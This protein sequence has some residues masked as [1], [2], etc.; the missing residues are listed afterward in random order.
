MNNIHTRIEN[1]RRDLGRIGKAEKRIS[2]Q[3][4]EYR[5]TLR[6]AK[7]RDEEQRLQKEGR[8]YGAGAF[9]KLTVTAEPAKRRKK[10]IET[11]FLTYWNC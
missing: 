6:Q 3:H 1:K 7:K 8:T 4:K 5:V 11:L 10:Y 2:D 9:N